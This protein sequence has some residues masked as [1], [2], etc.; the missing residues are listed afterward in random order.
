MIVY[1]DSS[2]PLRLLFGQRQVFSDWGKWD[3]AYTSSLLNLECRRVIDRL[4]M[5]TALNDHGVAHAG[6]ELRRLVRSV[7]RVTLSGSILDRASMPMPTVVKTLDAIHIATALAL[8]E[9]RHPE[10]VFV[11]HDRQ[12]A[13]AARAL[14]FECRGHDS[15]SA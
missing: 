10:L 3:R 4:R 11:T 8:R 14:G 5:Q 13:N 2:V 1:L 12:Q 15:D 7:D 9:R 6:S